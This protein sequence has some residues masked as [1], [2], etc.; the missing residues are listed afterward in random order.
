M[1]RKPMLDKEDMVHI[2]NGIIPS[3]RNEVMPFVATQTA[4]E[5][6]TLS[7]KDKYHM[8]SLTVESKIQ[9]K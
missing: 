4:L 6:I 2:Y 9:H 7:Q 8:I 5:I 3:H 1:T